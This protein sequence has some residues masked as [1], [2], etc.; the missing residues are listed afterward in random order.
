MVLVEENRSLLP[1]TRNADDIRVEADEKF[2]EITP[3]LLEGQPF[4]S[5]AETLGVP[6][7]S[8][9]LIA[10]TLGLESGKPGTLALFTQKARSLEAKFGAETAKAREARKKRL[11]KNK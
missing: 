6:I 3:K 5:V 1:K 4:E 7:E 11:A 2:L 9:R 8:V 10:R